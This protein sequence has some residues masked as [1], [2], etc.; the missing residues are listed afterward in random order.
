[1][2]LLEFKAARERLGI[3]NDVFFHEARRLSYQRKAALSVFSFLRQPMQE[4]PQVSK[5][6]LKKRAISLTLL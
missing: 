5:I 4:L 1:M 6:V 3:D 2:H